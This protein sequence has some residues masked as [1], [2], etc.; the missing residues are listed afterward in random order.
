M[1]D[2]DRMIYRQMRSVAVVFLLLLVGCSA[3]PAAPPTPT[4]DYK[5]ITQPLLLPLGALIVAV[6]G[7]TPTTAYW[8]AQFN[9]AAEGVLQAI[10][11]DESGKANT[12]RTGIA[13]IRAMP[14]N[15]QVLEDTRSTLLSIT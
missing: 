15:L 11:G 7:N 6:R 4:V 3:T 2:A 1:P 13:N 10:D 14:N 12:L 9:T 5:A 8:L